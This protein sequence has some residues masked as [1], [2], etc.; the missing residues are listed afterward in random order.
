VGYYNKFII[1]MY[2]SLIHHFM[3]VVGPIISRL[4]YCV[5]RHILKEC[6]GVLLKPHVW[7]NDDVIV[8]MYHVFLSHWS[9]GD[10]HSD[11][12]IDW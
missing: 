6:H 2:F 12:I 7:A 1:A 5:D 3:L 10:D 11:T 8:I 4:S 9:I